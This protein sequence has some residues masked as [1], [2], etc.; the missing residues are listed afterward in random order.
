MSS[1]R[2]ARMYFGHRN[3]E[4]LNGNIPQHIRRMSIDRKAWVNMNNIL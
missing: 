3:D 4:F 1:N 2:K